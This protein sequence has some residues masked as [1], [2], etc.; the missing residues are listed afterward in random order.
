MRRRTASH[1][2][3]SDVV[4]L[5]KWSDGTKAPFD[6]VA[7]FESAFVAKAAWP[8]YRTATWADWLETSRDYA[9]PPAAAVV[10]DG[11]SDCTDAVGWPMHNP[12]ASEVQDAADRDLEAIAA[13]RRRCPKDAEDIAEALAAFQAA[14]RLTAELATAT[15]GDPQAARSAYLGRPKTHIQALGRPA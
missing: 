1:G 2:P 3:L 7:P 11:L 15:D 12:P 10:Y 9:D 4:A 5:F 8:A 13:Y 14:V 6:F